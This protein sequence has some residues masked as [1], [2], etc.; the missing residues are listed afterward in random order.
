MSPPVGVWTSVAAVDTGGFVVVLG[1][2]HVTVRARLAAV[3]IR[4]RAGSDD[5]WVIASVLVLAVSGGVGL[6]TAPLSAATAVLAPFG[7]C[8]PGSAAGCSS[9]GSCSPPR[10]STAWPGPRRAPGSRR[11][12]RSGAR[13]S[14]TPRRAA[15][16]RA[17][18]SSPSPRGDGRP[19]WSGASPTPRPRRSRGPC[20]AWCASGPCSPDRR[21]RHVPHDRSTSRPAERARRGSPECPSSPG[22]AL[23]DRGGFPDVERQRGPHAGT[24]HCA[25]RASS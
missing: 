22:V 18:A 19:S 1:T 11:G 9:S 7:S 17:A 15:T 12:G 3:E 8:S 21:E 6:V 4:Q 23:G 13:P 10:T 25:G 2:R 24:D 16:A 5:D 20:A 14:C